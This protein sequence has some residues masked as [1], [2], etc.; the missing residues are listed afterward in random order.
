MFV[1]QRVYI[2]KHQHVHEFCYSTGRA[3]LGAA[4]CRLIPRKSS[5]LPKFA[6]CSAEILVLFCSFIVFLALEIEYVQYDLSECHRGAPGPLIKDYNSYKQGEITPVTHLFS[7]IYTGP[8]TPFITSLLYEKPC[9][10]KLF[11]FVVV[12]GKL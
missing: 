12:E 2:Y 8:T 4:G 10:H 5:Y 1:Y 7:A 9:H 6:S 3:S 11:Q